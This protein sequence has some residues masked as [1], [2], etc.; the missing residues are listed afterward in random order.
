MKMRER[1]QDTQACPWRNRH[2]EGRRAG[3][4]LT[5]M[6]PQITCGESGMAGWGHRG[7]QSH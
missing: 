7:N 6:N 4:F 2:K 1:C 5:R 3:A